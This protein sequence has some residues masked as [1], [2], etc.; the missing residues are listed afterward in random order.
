MVEGAA[1][2]AL[3]AIA[4]LAAS[5]LHDACRRRAGAEAAVGISDSHQSDAHLCRFGPLA[6]PTDPVTTRRLEEHGAFF[7]SLPAFRSQFPGAQGGTP[8]EAA[9]VRPPA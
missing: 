2:V 3:A 1:P 9:G 8:P 6:A 7:N 5:E 4:V